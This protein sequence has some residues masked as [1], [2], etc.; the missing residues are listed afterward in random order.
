VKL[1]VVLFNLGGPDS[2]EAITPFL[3]N[4]FSDPAIISLPEIV[5]LPLAWLLANRRA[6]Q[7]RDIYAKIGGASPIRRYTEEQARALESELK[8]SN[9]D[10]RVFVAMRYWHPLSDE[11]VRQVKEFEP[12]EIVALPLYPQFS[13]TTTGSSFAAWREAAQRHGLKVRT[14]AVC[15]YPIHYLFVTAH[16]GLL[17]RA[18]DDFSADDSV[19]ILFSAH[20][21]PE[22]VVAGGDPYQFQ[23]EQT[24]AAV[25]SALAR[26]NVEW[27]ICYQS[28]V[29]P[30]TWIG[31]PTEDEIRAAGADKRSLV[32]VPIAF[33][34]EHSETLV[35][36]DIDY[37]HLAAE[38]GVPRYV[39]LPA[40]GSQGDYIKALADLVR[41]ALERDGVTAGTGGRL[42]P[43]ALG[44]C[45][46]K[47]A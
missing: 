9:D 15:C 46:H 41:R 14:H 31:P 40:L 44:R 47:G 33:V 30:L 23:V 38:S 12:D 29:G 39:R 35:E 25:V 5:R 42:C 45:P 43:A 1:A 18:L 3:R 20:G 17:R 13:S 32:V 21:L 26:P 28:K 16:V 8:K 34:S 36:L 27:R 4:L 11:T 19:R 22:R 2:P 10:V 7:A 24:V 6:A 37:A